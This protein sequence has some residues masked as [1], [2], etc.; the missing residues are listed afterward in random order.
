MTNSRRSAFGGSF[1]FDRVTVVPHGI[2]YL[3]FSLDCGKENVVQEDT[4][5]YYLSSASPPLHVSSET[6]HFH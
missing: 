2:E 5:L 4:H 3:R 1:E 6:I